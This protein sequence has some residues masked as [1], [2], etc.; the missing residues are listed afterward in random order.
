MILSTML[1]IPVLGAVLIAL[2]GKKQ[3][4]IMRITAVA[5][6]LI[7]FLESIYLYLNFDT[8][9][10]GFQF[11]QY[12]PWISVLNA[13]Y[14][15][16]IDGISLPMVILTA[17][18]S[19]L[20]SLYVLQEKHRIKG[21]LALFL[22]LETGMLGVFVSLDFFLFFIFWEV[23]LVPMYFLIGI[24]GGEN[25]EYAA[26]K[27]FMYTLAGSVAILLGI[28]ILYFKSAP[29]TLDIPML[30]ASQPLSGNFRLATLVFWLLF[31]G[32]AIKVPVFPFHTWLPDAHVE[33][34]TPGSVILAGVLLKM[35]GYGFIRV[36]LPV[37]PE[38]CRTYAK[39]IAVLA[40]ISIVYGAFV[41]MAQTNLKK[42]VAYSS[43]SHM[44]Y[45]TLGVA[46]AMST[47]S[48]VT[49]R[50]VAL[51]GAVLQMFNHG[52]ITGGLF[53]LVGMIYSRTHNM[54]LSKFGGLNSRIPIYAGLASVTIF[55]SMG[56]PGLNGFVSEFM[57]FMG[58]YPVFPLVVAAALTGIIV[59]AAF[60]LWTIQRMF[61]GK[62]NVE[63]GELGDVNTVEMAIMLMLIFVMLII[64]IYPEPFVR[65]IDSGVTALVG[66]MG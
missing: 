10:Q 33:A 17:F 3:E 61:L 50:A 14:H 58:S 6:S 44:G 2:L 20:V 54:D 43:V 46:A 38:M 15:I 19:F 24:W 55:A 11:E 12:F 63:Y 53:F 37:L 22:L 29:H 60:L 66:M 25:R 47:G 13:N 39:I 7:V 31:V 26:I 30:I 35:G 51:N 9:R 57:V 65:L 40:L 34:P 18:L 59:T 21:Y 8:S 42:L 36:L 23:S 64:G 56:L 1:A 62:P 45:V 49:S 5:S 28:F 27:F 16:G 4:K 41:A 48:L 52:I 32:F